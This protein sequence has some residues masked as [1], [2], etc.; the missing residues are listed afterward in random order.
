MFAIRHFKADASTWTIKTR[1]GKQCA[2]GRGLSFYYNAATTSVA[3]IPMTA[4]TAPFIFN[5]QT[6]DFQEI[7]VQGELVWQ[8][9]EPAKTALVFNFSVGKHSGDY[10]SEDPLKLN[11]RVIRV[12]QALI[13]ERIQGMPLREV[14]TLGQSLATTVRDGVEQQG[15]LTPMGLTLLDVA[16]SRLAP[17]PETSRA[18]EATTREAILQEADDAMYGRRKS[19]VEQERSIRDA[20]LQTE[21]SVQQKEQEIATKRIDNERDLLRG[22]TATEQERIAANIDAENQKQSLVVLRARNSNEQADAEAYAINARMAAYQTLPVEHMKALAMTQ[23]APEQLLAVAMESFANNAEKI[24]ELNI[25][26]DL[27]SQALRRSTA[28]RSQPRGKQ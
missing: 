12:A 14:L 17:T 7:T 18:L 23:M 6:A 11:D 9:Q 2:A 10:L 20:E 28:P 24:G 27:L 8:V 13:E 25:G 16:I 21:L 15:T 4:Q 26:P 3:A 19:A 5:L 22:Q 1:N